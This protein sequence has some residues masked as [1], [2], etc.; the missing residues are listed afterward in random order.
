MRVLILG[1]GG[2]LGTTLTRRLL[3]SGHQVTILD[4]F[5]WGTD[6]VY[7]L[8][9]AVRQCSPTAAQRLRVVR[10]DTRSFAALPHSKF[11]GLIGAQ[12][13]VINLAAFPVDQWCDLNEWTSV[14]VNEWGTEAVF[15]YC[16]R[17]RVEKVVF[18]SSCS[19][20]GACGDEWVDEQSELK[21]HTLY[22]R[23]KQRMEQLLEREYR[24][25]N[26]VIGR[27]ATLFGLSLKMRLDIVVNIMTA[28]ACQE[29][30][31][32]VNGAGQQWRPLLH[33]ADAAR[34]LEILLTTDQQVRHEVFNVG[35]NELVLRVADLPDRIKAG[36][37]LE[38]VQVVRAE[39]SHDPRSHRMN[40]RKFQERFG[41][42]AS[43]GIEQGAGEIAQAF[44]NNRLNGD[45]RWQSIKWLD[46]LRQFH[47]YLHESGSVPA[48]DPLDT[49]PEMEEITDQ[50]LD[51]ATRSE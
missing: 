24:D 18:P 6:V 38:D 28:R 21:P 37:D 51:A 20:Y 10:G 46:S 39:G 45:I 29:R 9:E 50:F 40:C 5:F 31:I 14:S 42:R 12:E 15:Q 11:Q 3:E 34:A 43:M 16:R 19:S 27:L 33:V 7:K 2:Y 17:A 32:V 22:A 25:V 26:W 23:G 47:R 8:L 44:E 36:V 41:F 48:G 49:V 4:R 13:A 1:G 30:K 35:D